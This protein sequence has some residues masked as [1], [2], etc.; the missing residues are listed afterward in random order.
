MF[1]ISF[2]IETGEAAWSVEDGEAA[3]GILVD[4]HGGADIVPAVGLL[5]NLEAAA[6]KRHAIVGTDH[7][8]LLNAQHV[9]ERSAGIGHEGRSGLGGRHREAG[10]VIGYEAFPQVP[11]GG[12]HGLD[13]G[14]AQLLRQPLLQR[15]EHSSR[16][17]TRS[18]SR[19]SA[20]IQRWVEPSWNSN[21][22]G[23]GR[24]S[25]FLRWALR[26]LAFATSPAACS[27][28]LVTV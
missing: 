13:P 22:P 7:A 3:V 15:P 21:I 17:T 2:W 18:R 11:V 5:R 25:R 26:R 14:Q 9:L 28:A 19:P 23:S 20:V 4:P 6:G 8:I 12:R 16:V 24:R 10:I 27:D 1:G